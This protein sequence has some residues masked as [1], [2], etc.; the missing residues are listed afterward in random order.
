VDQFRASA[1]RVQLFSRLASNCRFADLSVRVD[2]CFWPDLF[3]GISQAIAGSQAAHSV[4][5]RE[6]L[7]FCFIVSVH[8]IHLLGRLVFISK[9]GWF[10]LFCIVMALVMQIATRETVAEMKMHWKCSSWLWVFA[11][12]AFVASYAGSY[13]GGHALLDDGW[14]MLFLAVSD[15]I[16]IWLAMRYRMPDASVLAETADI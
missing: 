5:V 2:V 1:Y 6:N 14:V 16:V 11:A 9:T 15:L 8:T 3:A 4:A 7:D 12:T 10:L 13:G